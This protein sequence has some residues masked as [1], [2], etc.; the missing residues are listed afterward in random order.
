MNHEIAY[1]RQAYKNTHCAVCQRQLSFLFIARQ[2]DARHLFGI[3]V[4]LS[5][6]HRENEYTCG[7]V[8]DP[9]TKFGHNS[10]FLNPTDVTEFDGE[11]LDGCVK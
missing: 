9:C 4:C 5:D 10:S 1:T 11:L 3:Y 7:P 6:C 2:H 8:F